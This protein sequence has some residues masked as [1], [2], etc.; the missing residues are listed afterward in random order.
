[1]N[2]LLAIDLGVKT[3]LALYNQDCKLEWY[4]SKNFG[5]KNSLN[6]ALYSLLK[7]VENLE[8][9]IIEGGGDLFT[10][11]EKQAKKQGIKVI[12]IQAHVWRKELLLQREQ[13]NGQ[14]AKRYAIQIAN[15]VIK[16]TSGKK[17]TSLSD[18][19]AEAILTG[20]WALSEVN[21]LNTSNSLFKIKDKT[22]AYFF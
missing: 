17:A 3:G 10:I 6:K 8:F 1:M 14:Q 16:H 11:W 7:T 20:Y 13:R 5:S 21:W 9:L 12:Q 15:E 4:R 18:D 19:A 22:Q 2:K